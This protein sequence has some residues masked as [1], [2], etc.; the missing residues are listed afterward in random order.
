MMMLKLSFLLMALIY[1]FS[2]AD[3]ACA[4]STTSSRDPATAFERFG[5]GHVRR[6]RRVGGDDDDDD[7]DS[8]PVQTVVGS[9]TGLLLMNSNIDKP[10][11]KIY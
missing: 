8:V 1:G 6:N 7:D 9:I 5:R 3:A 4:L 10:I 11:R 2:V